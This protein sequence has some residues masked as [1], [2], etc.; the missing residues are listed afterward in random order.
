[1]IYETARP[2]PQVGNWPR[3]RTRPPPE[4]RSNWPQEIAYVRLVI[5]LVAGR[6]NV[7]QTR[8]MPSAQ[9]VSKAQAASLSAPLAIE[10]RQEVPKGARS[11]P[12]SG[13]F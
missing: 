8:S 7:G 2:T 3:R 5:G 4:A 6:L 11:S 13:I 12:L 9:R 1:M 10:S